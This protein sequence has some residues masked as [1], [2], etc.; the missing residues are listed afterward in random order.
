MAKMVVF[1]PRPRGN[2]CSRT[3]GVSPIASMMLSKTRPRP[4]C[5]EARVV[6]RFIH[7]LVSPKKYILDFEVLFQ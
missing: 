7:G 4:R 3:I 2:R 1:A 5:C 6:E